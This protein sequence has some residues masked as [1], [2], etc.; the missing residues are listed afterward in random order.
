MFLI[1]IEETSKWAGHAHACSTRGW[2]GGHRQWDFHSRKKYLPQT[3]G[4]SDEEDQRGRR[5]C[6]GSKGGCHS[7]RWATVP[8][9]IEGTHYINY[10]TR[11]DRALG[12]NI[13]FSSQPLPP[14]TKPSCSDTT[15][16]V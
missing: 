9:G 12:E 8:V 11:L 15:R 5:P 16:L 3:W 4:S 10:K 7:Q 2:L 13:I 6:H 1:L 14:M